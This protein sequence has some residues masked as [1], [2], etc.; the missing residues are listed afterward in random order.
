MKDNSDKVIVSLFDYTGNWCQPYRE[1]GYTV[2]QHDIKFGQDIFEDTVPAAVDD[3]VEGNFVHGIMAAVPCTDFALS[4][5]RHWAEKDKQESPVWS[6]DVVFH[7]RLDYWQTMVYSTLLVIEM[8][9]PKWW[10]IENPVGRIADVV[11][12]LKKYRMLSFH[13]YEFG[14]PYKKRTILYGEFNPWLTRNLVKPVKARP[15][16]HSIDEYYFL[17]GRSRKG[18]ARQ[19]SATPIGFAWAFYNANP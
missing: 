17:Q 19:R 14:D 7:S 11:P 18:R 13:P 16:H 5:A 1:N 6:K 15:G 9:R 12:E 8:L 2:I 4:G 3:H 10:V